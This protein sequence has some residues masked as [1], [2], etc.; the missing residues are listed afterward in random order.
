MLVALKPPDYCIQVTISQCHWIFD[1][2][3]IPILLLLVLSN[4][5]LCNPLTYLID[6][7][8]R[9]EG[10]LSNPPCPPLPGD[11]S[12]QMYTNATEPQDT[13]DGNRTIFANA[14]VV[15]SGATETLVQRESLLSTATLASSMAQPTGI[16]EPRCQI[17]SQTAH[18]DY[19]PS[20]IELGPF[21]LQPAI[22]ELF[23][24][25]IA[26]SYP[27]LR[28]I[29]RGRP[30]DT[31]DIPHSYNRIY[32][33]GAGVFTLRRALW[34]KISIYFGSTEPKWIQCTLYQVMMSDQNLVTA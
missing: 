28:E 23:W 20:S 4:G 1:M 3:T 14:S 9:L 26:S 16:T 5:V 33:S 31:P 18:Y 13:M 24:I 11:Y 21:W 22:S 8:P 29:V 12:W 19:R 7:Q 2:H 10:S 17:I 32:T 27:V 25:Q 34:V 6:D 30:V 15:Q